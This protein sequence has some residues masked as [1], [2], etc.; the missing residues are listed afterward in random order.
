MHMDPSNYNEML[1]QI[2]S[3][4]VLEQD[5]ILS[6]FLKV[7]QLVITPYLLMFIQFSFNNVIFPKIAIVVPIFKSIKKEQANNYHPI[8]SFLTCFSKIVEKVYSSQN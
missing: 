3:N 6:Y 1:N 5:N 2:M 8:I 4:K 7:A